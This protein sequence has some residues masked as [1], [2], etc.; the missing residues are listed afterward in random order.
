MPNPKGPPSSIVQLRIAVW[1]D[2][3]RD[4]TPI[5][6][7]KTVTV[8]L[9]DAA[10]KTGS[11]GSPQVE[12]EKPSAEN[13]KANQKLS[14]ELMRIVIDALMEVPTLASAAAKAGIHRKKL[15]YRLKCSK[16]GHA[17]Y[18]IEYRGERRRFH[19]HCEVAIAEAHDTLEFLLW[20]LAMGIMF[21]IDPSLVKLGHR[22]V[23]G[24]AMDENG[25]YIV[26]GVRRPNVKILRAL[27]A[28]KRP[29]RWGKSPKRDISRTGGVLVLGKRT[30]DT[31]ASIKAR[32]W[33]S[34]SKLVRGSKD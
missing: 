5:G 25:N 11:S 6:D 8:A 18:D 10:G 23:D 1:T 30:V 31:T 27:L 28:W 12:E 16:A 14:H 3:A 26:E 4:T 20:Q 29:E 33:K 15:E 22:G 32:K 17:G 9:G 34:L 19:E 13:S 24:Y 21:K 7:S 2:D